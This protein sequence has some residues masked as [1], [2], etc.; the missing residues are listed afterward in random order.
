MTNH[1]QKKFKLNTGDEIP[2]VGLGMWTLYIARLGMVYGAI[3]DRL[4]GL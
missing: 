3:L 1:T 2:A 4:S